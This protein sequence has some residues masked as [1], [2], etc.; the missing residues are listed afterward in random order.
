MAVR[1]HG[2]S[3]LMVMLTTAL[4]GSSFAISKIGLA[5]VSPLLLAGVRFVFAGFLMVSAV[6]VTGRP[7]PRALTHGLR[8]AA[9]G[10]FQTAGV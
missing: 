10:L 1:H 2:L 4:M 3:V 8:V 6:I 7:R 5:Y 9:V